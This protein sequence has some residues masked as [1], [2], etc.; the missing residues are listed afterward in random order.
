VLFVV[1]VDDGILASIN[2]CDI[3]KEIISL[4]EVFNISIEG[5]LSDYVGVNIERTGNGQIH[6]T[7]PNIIKSI[8]KDLNLTPNTKTAATPAHS[9]TILQDGK[10][11]PSHSADW[12]YRSVIGKLNFLSSLCR[13]ELS[14]SVHQAARF[15]ADPRVNHTDAVKRIA[16]YLQGTIDKGIIYTP[17]EHLFEV[18][19]D[20]DF[21]GLWNREEA[22]DKP[23]TAKSRTGYVMKYAGCPI[24]WGSTL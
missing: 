15:S 18:Y 1:Y 8:L 4:Q 10:K 6:M 17:T 14:C 20:A 5:N 2:K 21:G 13:P 9:T 19:V 7:Q 3:D 22:S 23:I 12:N 16:R 24:V 11:M